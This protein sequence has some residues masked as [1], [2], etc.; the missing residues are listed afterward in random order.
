MKY[1]IEGTYPVLR[2]YLERDETIITSAGNMSWMTSG[3]DYKVQ[4]GGIKK[5]FG[6]AFTGEGFFQ[7]QYTAKDDNQ[8]I[9]FAMTMPGV[10]DPHYLDGTKNY[11]VQKS[12]FLASE[13][14]VTFDTFFTK[15]IST[16]LFGGEGFILQKFSGTGH[17]FLEADGSLIDY[18]L[19]DGEVLLVDQ[20]NLFMF[21]ESV[22]FDIQTVKGLGNKLFGGEGFFLA[23]L[24]GPGLVKLQTLPISNLAGEVNRVL[25]TSN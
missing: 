4:S 1:K 3:M 18:N 20:G 24:T 14:T 12:A 7:N 6:R 17:L 19:K 9:A 23:K 5:S 2:C 13:D 10:I 25:P 16:G 22:K 21:E 8:E 15:K 11:I